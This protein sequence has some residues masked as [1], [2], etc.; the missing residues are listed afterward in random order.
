MNKLGK[1]ILIFAFL[2]VFSNVVYAQNETNETELP[3]QVTVE[4]VK[5]KIDFEENARFKI[6]IDNPRTSIERFSIRPAAPYVE[7]FI[8]TDP[9]LDYS[10]KAYPNLKREVFVVVKPLGVGIGRYSLRLN[11]KHDASKEIFKKDII[12]NVVSMSNLPAVSISG[13]LPEKID[14]REPF[15]VTVWLENRNAKN[16]EDLKVELKSDVIRDSTITSLGPVGSGTDKK[17]LEFSFTLDKKTPP[18]KDSVRII[19]TAGQDDD[20]YELK[21]SMYDYEIIKYGELTD[22]H[23]QRFRLFG[24]YDEISFVNDANTKYEGV[25]KIE[26]PFYRALFTKA[27]PKSESFVEDGKRYIGW[28]VSLNAQEKFDVIVKV[29]Y[30]PLIIVLIV[31]SVMIFSYFK[32]RSPIIL[33]KFAKDVMKKEGGI[34]QFIILLHV[35]NRSNKSIENVAIIDKVPDI[36]DFEKGTEVGTLQ[37]SKVVHTKNGV[38]AKW[39]I[40]SLDKDGETVI[41]YRVKSRLSILGKL[42]LPIT[43]AKFKD[44]KGAVKRSYSN[45][46]IVGN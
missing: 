31:F 1:I 25:A 28:N 40:D 10:V 41:K 34:T 17:T 30:I 32:F 16:L 37:P 3:F 7:W 27:T 42:P 18:R 23:N 12:V 9:I 43:I 5:D 2:V 4:P 13:K 8:K 15:V 29:N 21:S 24:R 44:E 39:I 11:V 35:K 33:T 6:I 19:V 22:E 45:R 38:I 46:V 26:N 20:I 36:A 14:P